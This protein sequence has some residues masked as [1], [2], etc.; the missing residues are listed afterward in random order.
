VA[1]SCEHG[2]E[3]FESVEDG[4]FLDYMSFVSRMAQSV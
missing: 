3:H 2:N 4:E 1:G